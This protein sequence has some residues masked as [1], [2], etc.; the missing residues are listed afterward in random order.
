M[1]V[2]SIIDKL[3]PHIG[4]NMQTTFWRITNILKEHYMESMKYKPESDFDHSRSIFIFSA[5]YVPHSHN[6]FNSS[7][8]RIAK[9]LKLLTNIYALSQIL[10]TLYRYCNL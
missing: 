2:G 8:C 10:T 9:A 3:K 4:T 6:N 1:C 7:E 5:F